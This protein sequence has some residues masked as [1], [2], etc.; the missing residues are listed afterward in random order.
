M[1]PYSF[2]FYSSKANQFPS[3]DIG[4]N[5]YSPANRFLPFMIKKPADQQLV[6]CIKVF[7]LSDQMA[8]LV[9]P[10]NLN[11]R[12]YSGGGFDYI[13]YY[14]AIIQGMNLPCGKY[15]LQVGAFFSEV[16]TVVDVSSMLVLEWQN[17]VNI[18]ADLIYQNGFFQRVYLDAIIADPTYK[19]DQEGEEDGFDNFIPTFTKVSKQLSFQTDL[20]PEF[21]VDALALLP[22][23]DNV[24]VGKYE[25][26]KAIELD[27]DWLVSG[28][29]GSV[30]IKFNE[31]EA[32]VAKICNEPLELVE[33]DQEG[34]TPKTWLCNGE[35]DPNPYFVK[36]GGYT[37]Y[38]DA[39]GEN[40]GSSIA[41]ERDINPNSPSYNQ[42]RTVAIANDQRCPI[43]KVETFDSD[44]ISEII[45][46]NDCQVGFYGT[47]VNY[48]LDAGHYIST[49]S[50]ADANLNARAYFDS[51]KQAHANS[52]GLCLPEDSAEEDQNPC[53]EMG[54]AII[55]NAGY[56][57]MIE[58]Y[59][60]NEYTGQRCARWVCVP[61]D[62]DN[63]D[64]PATGPI[65]TPSQG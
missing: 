19:V 58:Y 46:R 29:A 50:K 40:T 21:L 39:N 25:E 13:F 56:E 63:G 3:K 24:T 48:K 27:V 45:F 34:Y 32:S 1:Q 37:C 36:T 28:V 42:T 7:T 54:N 22:L 43:K 33:V 26:V 52:H 31:A 49:I 12:M 60:F 65:G 18:G 23:H 16:F 41:E 57:S 6:D 38:L 5:L 30:E 8:Y 9:E 64:G 44:S 20:L 17:S 11:Y 47:G 62:V 10:E 35:P 61:S 53:P 4:W 59:T 55:C 15:Y 51:T 14:A 2:P